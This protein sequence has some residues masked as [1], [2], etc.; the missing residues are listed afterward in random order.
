[1]SDAPADVHSIFL[2]FK[3]FEALKKSLTEA[4]DDSIVATHGTIVDL[5]AIRIY[6]EDDQTVRKVRAIT[7]SMEGRSCVYE[8]ENGE[9]ISF[10][11]AKLPPSVTCP[12]MN[13]H[14]R[15]PT[16]IA[17]GWANR[18]AFDSGRGLRS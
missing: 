7:E 15:S 5:S 18:P 4:P 1:M 6:V 9:L 2:S 17:P 14:T 12:T 10:S 8:G 11:P 13:Q 3:T 16:N